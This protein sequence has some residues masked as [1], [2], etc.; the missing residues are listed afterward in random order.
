MEEDNRTPSY[1]ERRNS[2]PDVPQVPYTGPERRKA[3]REEFGRN[4]DWQ[5]S[6]AD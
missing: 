5:R 3:P 6:L 1:P 4:D 2:A